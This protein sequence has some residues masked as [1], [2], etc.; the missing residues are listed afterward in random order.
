MVREGS[1]TAIGSVHVWDW[2]A[3]QGPLFQT[4]RPHGWRRLGGPVYS[5]A[6]AICMC[7][8]IYL[9]HMY[10]YEFIVIFS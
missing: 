3:A 4:S 6:N 2:F 7:L 1:M 8:N 5:D 10:V 9:D